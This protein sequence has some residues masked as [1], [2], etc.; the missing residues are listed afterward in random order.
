[1]QARTNSGRL[2]LAAGAAAIAVGL[3]GV[4]TADASPEASRKRFAIELSG[5][6][7]VPTNPHGAADHG[8]VVLTLHQAQ[9]QIC[10]TFG[11]LTLTAGETLPHMAH[12]HRAPVGEAGDIVVTLFG[13]PAGTTPAPT[14]YPTDTVCVD[15]PFDIIK[16]I[17]KDPAAFYVNAHNMEHPTGVVRGQ[18]G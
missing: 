2:R 1:M 8:S 14:A 6:E 10:W 11:P 3:F 17:R 9:G 16:E 18:L 12:I 5:A 13:P 7:E 15:A 4:A